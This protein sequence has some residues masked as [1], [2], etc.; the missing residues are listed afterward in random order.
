MNVRPSPRVVL[1]TGASRGI[2]RAVAER[3]ANEGWTVVL[4]AT[5]PG[6]LEEAAES[7][8][9]SGGTVHVAAADISDEAAVAV[10]FDSIGSGIGRLDAVVNN[11]GMQPLIDGRAPTIEELSPERW[12]RTIDVNL[13]GAFLVSR[14]ALPLMKRQRWGRFVNMGS[15]A[16]RT[17]ATNVAYGVT[18]AGLLGLSRMLAKEGGPYGITSNYIAPGFVRTEMMSEFRDVAGMEQRTIATTPLGRVGE[19]T[20]VTGV[21]AFLLSADAGY[22][23]G[24]ALDVNGGSFMA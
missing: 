20:D 17:T 10:M 16:G 4:N 11:A 2:G 22:L 24:A 8:R 1:V 9:K 7:I 15:R 14:E 23:N 18:K 5:R 6:P 19:T 13:T 12:R 3:L 21:V